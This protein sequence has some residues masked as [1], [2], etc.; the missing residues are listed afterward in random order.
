MGHISRVCNGR[1][2]NKLKNLNIILIEKEE[3]ERERTGTF[4]EAHHS[5][6]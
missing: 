2:T 1:R 4:T 6:I 3:R 5:D